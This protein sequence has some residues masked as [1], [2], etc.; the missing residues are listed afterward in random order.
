V[1][2]FESVKLGLVEY[3]PEELFAVHGT[4]LSRRIGRWF[5]DGENES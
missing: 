1:A 3:Q 2:E 5:G 4:C